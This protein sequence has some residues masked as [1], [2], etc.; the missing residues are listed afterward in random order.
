[1]I[2]PVKERR[3]RSCLVCSHY[4]PAAPHCSEWCNLTENYISYPYRPDNCN[5]N[6]TREEVIEIFNEYNKQ[7]GEN[8]G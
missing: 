1:M 2:P 4:L 3:T 5:F 8:C 6:F 7:E